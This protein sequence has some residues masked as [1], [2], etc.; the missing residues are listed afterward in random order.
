LYYT[1][2]QAI[3][4]LLEKSSGKFAAFNRQIT[5]QTFLV[6]LLQ[7]IFLDSFLTDQSIDVNISCLSNAMTSE[8]EKDKF[9][10]HKQKSVVLKSRYFILKLR[11]PVTY[12][13]FYEEQLS[14]KHGYL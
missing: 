10:N 3:N 5:Q 1:S 2:L 11:L 13:V 14:S 9:V 12:Y 8:M 6:G 4:Y 7:D